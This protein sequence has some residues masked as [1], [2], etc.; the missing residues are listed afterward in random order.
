[1]R[2]SYY[3]CTSAGCGVKK[4]IERSSEDTSIVVTTYEGQHTHLTSAMPRGRLGF[5]PESATYG[6]GSSSFCHSPVTSS[7]LIPSLSNNFYAH[8][9]HQQHQYLQ[10]SPPSLNI[11]SA[12]SAS[13]VSPSSSIASLNQDHRRQN[14]TSPSLPPSSSSLHGDHGLLQD[15]VPSQTGKETDE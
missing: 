14:L 15:I 9:H 11:I 10:N 2:R 6:G 7:F 4:R 8:Q 1:M 13:F 12:A 5:S 3:R